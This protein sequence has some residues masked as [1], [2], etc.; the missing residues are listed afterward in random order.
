M[1]INVSLMA[2]GE[3]F[4]AQNSPFVSVSHTRPACAVFN[5]GRKRDKRT[6]S[7][8]SLKSALSVKVPGVTIRTTRRSIIAFLSVVIASTCSEIA[9][10]SPCFTNRARYCSRVAA[11]IPAMGMGLFSKVPRRVSVSPKILEILTASSKKVS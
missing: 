2:S 6:E 3:T 4:V 1:R 9:T 7:D 5:F 10:D 8:F 11:G